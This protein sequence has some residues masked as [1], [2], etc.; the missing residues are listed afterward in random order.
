MF[1]T[2]KNTDLITINKQQNNIK[3]KTEDEEEEERRQ[4]D[5]AAGWQI[6]ERGIKQTDRYSSESYWRNEG[7]KESCSCQLPNAEPHRA[8]WHRLSRTEA[9]NKWLSLRSCWDSGPDQT[10]V[11]PTARHFMAKS[12]VKDKLASEQW[13]LE[14]R[15]LERPL[16]S[17]LHL[18][19]QKKKD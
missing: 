10:D 3:C 13:E 12:W 11:C 1:Y 4:T 14:R 18:Q 5:R 7:G 17:I 16:P 9:A 8:F 19:R 6:K 15:D 2:D